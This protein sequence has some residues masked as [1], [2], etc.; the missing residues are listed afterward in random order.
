MLDVVVEGIAI[1]DAF[2]RQPGGSSAA[3]RA[4]GRHGRQEHP[5]AVRETSFAH[6]SPRNLRTSLTKAAQAGSRGKRMWLQLSSATNLAPGM[7]LAISLPCSNGTAASS[8]QCS[9][10]VGAGLGRNQ[11]I[12]GLLH[13]GRQ[14]IGVDVLPLQLFLGHL[15]SPAG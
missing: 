11:R 12:E 6:P 1:P 14:I 4:I 8:R 5:P 3:M 7:R 15:L 9:T 10:S 2:K 13:V